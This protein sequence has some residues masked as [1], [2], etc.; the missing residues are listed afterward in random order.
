VEHFNYPSVILISQRAILFPFFDLFPTGGRE[1]FPR[2]N[3]SFPGPKV[4]ACHKC[5]KGP[6]PNKK[7]E[8]L[9]Q[10]SGRKNVSFFREVFSPSGWKKMCFNIIAVI[11]N[12]NDLLCFNDPIIGI[13]GTL[14][15]NSK[16]SI[17]T[18][19]T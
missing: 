2:E 13:I 15:L 3:F 14:C 18:L 1:N 10:F 16:K 4:G 17:L 9:G 8:K 6:C 5:P 12:F 11:G 19:A 7:K